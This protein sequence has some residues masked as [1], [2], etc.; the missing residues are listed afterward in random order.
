MVNNI[1]PRDILCLQYAGIKPSRIMTSGL[2]IVHPKE[3]APLQ[4]RILE[5]GGLILSEQPI[6]VKANPTRLVAR[7]RLQAAL[8]D[9]VILAECPEHSGSMHTMRFA[10]K[11][12]KQCFAVSYPEYSEINAG[13]ELLINLNIAKSI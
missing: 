12:H 5:N 4:Q 2:D 8:S 11:F 13:N 3:N 7:T 9:A 6:G 10:R 1:S